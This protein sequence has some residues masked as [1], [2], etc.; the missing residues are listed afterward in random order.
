VR[1][2]RGS[3]AG[4][5]DDDD[6]DDEEDDDDEDGDG[7]AGSAPPK[8]RGGEAAGWGAERV[9]M[10]TRPG[11]ACCAA[12]VECT[13]HRARQMLSARERGDNVAECPCVPS[14]GACFSLLPVPRAPNKSKPH[15]NK[16]SG[17]LRHDSVTVD[18]AFSFSTAIL[19]P[20]IL[21][22]LCRYR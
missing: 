9:V 21:S 3:A 6:D 14:K 19:E 12:F 4:Y 1:G 2:R 15:T 10:A 16:L 5:E 7:D 8:V 17:R 22:D 11:R 18:V 13:L 20:P